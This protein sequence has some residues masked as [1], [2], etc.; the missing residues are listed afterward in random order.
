MAYG[1]NCILG[2]PQNPLVSHR[3]RA[4]SASDA[5]LRAGG[6]VNPGVAGAPERG[7]RGR[8]PDRPVFR[9]GRK[10]LEATPLRRAHRPLAGSPGWRRGRIGRIGTRCHPHRSQTA[11]AAA[12]GQAPDSRSRLSQAPSIAGGRAQGHAAWPQGAQARPEAIGAGGDGRLGVMEDKRQAVVRLNR[13][14]KELGV[15]APDGAEAEDVM[16]A[17]ALRFGRRGRVQPDHPASVGCRAPAGQRLDHRRRRGLAVRAGRGHR[18]VRRRRG[19]RARLRACSLG[20]SAPVLAASSFRS[21]TAA[22]SRA[23]RGCRAR[24]LTGPPSHST[25]AG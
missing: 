25:P 23:V 4:L 15:L 22:E 5:P 1:V 16:A 2:S 8:S 21:S 18:A 20:M 19:D 17:P 14:A 7:S 11:P 6:S 13:S 3:F 24:S 10:L 9:V 12:D